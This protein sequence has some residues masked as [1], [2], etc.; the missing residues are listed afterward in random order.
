M[1]GVFAVD[2]D[3]IALEPDAGGVMVANIKLQGTNTLL[4][5]M[6]GDEKDPDLNFTK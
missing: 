5:K 1:K 4:F 6:M 3:A 2:G